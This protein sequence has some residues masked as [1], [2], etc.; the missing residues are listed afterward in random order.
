MHSP[1]RHRDFN[2]LINRI[3]ET[4]QITRDDQHSINAIVTSTNLEIR[5]VLRM[6]TLMNLIAEGEIQVV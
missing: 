2:D 5:D 6:S 4:G 3:I 1:F